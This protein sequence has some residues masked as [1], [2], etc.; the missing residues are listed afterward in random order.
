MRIF[1]FI[2]ITTQGSAKT[3]YYDNIF[4]PFF[5]KRPF[6]ELKYISS[7]KISVGLMNEYKRNHPNATIKE[8][9]KETRSYYKKA[10]KR[11]IRNTFMSIYEEVINIYEKK[12][13]NKLFFVYIDKYHPLNDS[14]QYFAHQ[15]I[16]KISE[17]DDLKFF[18]LN[19]INRR[20]CKQ[21]NK[22]LYYEDLTK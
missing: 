16:K 17:Y 2:P 3:F 18:S 11:K 1:I 15:K 9:F 8:S 19:M 14:S 13:K 5:K 21:A 10:Y 7:E 20:F 22:I 12:E 4:K 6:I